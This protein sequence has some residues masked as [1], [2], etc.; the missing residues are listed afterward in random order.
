[1]N[2]D[3][4]NINNNNNSKKEENI[5]KEDEL[6]IYLNKNETIYIK[7]KKYFKFIN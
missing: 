3:N 5:N 4:N 1:M 6:H 7:V 2:L